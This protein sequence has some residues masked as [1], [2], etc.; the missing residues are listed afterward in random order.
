MSFRYLSHSILTSKCMMNNINSVPSGFTEDHIIEIDIEL[1]KIKD[2]KRK[3]KHRQLTAHQT[4]N[5][6]QKE[7]KDLKTCMVW[8]L[9]ISLL[10]HIYIDSKALR[11]LRT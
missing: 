4:I 1:R 7:L 10:H 2:S 6:L 8:T 9:V 5:K 3:T 11:R